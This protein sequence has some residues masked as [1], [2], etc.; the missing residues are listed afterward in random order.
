MNIIAIVGVGIVAALISIVIKQY[1]PEFGMY[2]SLLTGVIILFAVIKAIAPVLETL[3]E[4][5]EAVSLD[6]LYGA[7]LLKALA[8]C[9][10]IQLASDTCRD[11]GETAIAGKIEMAGKLAI[12]LVSLPLFKG[13][14]DIVTGL[15][16][17]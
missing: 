1:K 14:V 10:I 5:T 17:L 15:I 12:V 13:V 8:I 11:S 9:Y 4:L 6:P 2:I 7:A 3:N 16:N